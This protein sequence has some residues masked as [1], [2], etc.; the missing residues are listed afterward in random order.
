MHSISPV[1]QAIQS[2]FSNE[3]A[4]D[5]QFTNHSLTVTLPN[6][7]KLNIVVPLIVA[8]TQLL[9]QPF[10]RSSKMIHTY[11]YLHQNEKILPARLTLQSIEDCRS[12]VDDICQTM[13]NANM[14]DNEI[15]F[16]DGSV[17][18]IIIK[19]H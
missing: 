8:P 6:K 2:A 7:K 17:Y 14:R 13:L 19:A 9:T 10:F 3:I 5:F 1:I 16:P 4:N 11:H 18:L 12:Y 15:T